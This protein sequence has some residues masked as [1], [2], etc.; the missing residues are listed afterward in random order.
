MVPDDV[1]L[2]DNS[3]LTELVS[4]QHSGFKESALTDLSHGSTSGFPE[5]RL[6]PEINLNTGDVRRGNRKQETPEGVNPKRRL[7][8]YL[9]QLLQAHSVHRDLTPGTFLPPFVCLLQTNIR[10][11]HLL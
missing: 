5:R 7:G 11:T 3:W 4:A 8:F 10:F 1:G 2:K 9:L 6:A